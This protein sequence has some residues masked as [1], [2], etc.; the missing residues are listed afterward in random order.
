MRSSKNFGEPVR[1]SE[2]LGKVS[3]P[4]D[5]AINPC[6]TA[7]WC[8]VVLPSAKSHDQQTVLRLAEGAL[9]AASRF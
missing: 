3:R 9:Q 4:P 5:W 2:S 6:F 1:S 7:I 8:G